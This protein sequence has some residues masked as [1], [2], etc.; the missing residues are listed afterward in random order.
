M[1]HFLHLVGEIFYWEAAIGVTLISL[2]IVFG[3]IYLGIFYGD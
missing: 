3:I 2:F 1:S